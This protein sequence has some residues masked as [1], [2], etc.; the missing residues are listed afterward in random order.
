MKRLLSIHI[1]KAGGSSFRHTLKSIYSNYFWSYGVEAEKIAKSKINELQCLHGHI[2]PMNY[3]HLMPDALV[4]IW[5]REPISRFKSYY[6][7]RKYTRQ[8]GKINE[9][10]K[11]YSS[12]MEWIRSENSNYLKT[13]MLNYINIK[14]LDK[15]DFIGEIE[16]YDKDL[17]RLMNMLGV[18]KYK[19]MHTNKSKTPE[20][21]NLS[22]SDISFIKDKFKSEFNIYEMI[23]NNICKGVK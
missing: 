23:K 9:I 10:M 6:N 7:Y 4:I 17:Q 13:E 15:F 11:K 2:N 18:T 12:F 1:P 8:D 21:I 20:E 19:Q 22:E 14:T 5:V 16:N 3:I